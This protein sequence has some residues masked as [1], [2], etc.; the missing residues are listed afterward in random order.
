ML[1]ITLAIVLSS[2]ALAQ[3]PFGVGTPEPA[4]MPGTGGGLFGP[5]FAQIAAWQSEFYRT[6]T[7]ALAA[8]REDGAAFWLLG[9]VSF[10][11]GIF[12]AAGPGH[13]KAVISAYILA[14]G[15]TLRRGVLIAFIASFVQ[16]L[17]AVVLVS[18]AAGV[19]RVTAV[20]MT[21]ATDILEIGSYAL[22]IFIGVWMI[23]SKIFR[24]GHHHSPQTDHGR[25]RWRAELVPANATGPSL[26]F[27]AHDHA[28]HQFLPGSQH[29][30]THTVD[31][32]LLRRPLT[33]ASAWTAIAAVGIRPCTGAVIVL[34]FALSQGLFA[35]GIVST[36]LM[37]LGTAIT[38]AALA[39]LAV[40]ARDTA[41]RL[42][43]KGS[44][45]IPR[46]IRG[47]EIL[48]AAVLVLLGALLL[49]G[50]L[51]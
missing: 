29:G 31:P 2:A 46:V 30:H 8:L 44:T 19:L 37:A 16:A 28:D 34:V 26:A 51:S 1:G 11:Y 47:M 15:E 39:S 23:Y 14:S 38:V 36:L 10:L 40:L 43:G 3:G 17:V 22:I 13:G 49:G 50:A 5:L 21:A 45:L 27:A 6:L 12:H 4:I 25:S 48:A 18:V 20:S 42:S 33:L 24:T 32:S 9:G 35:A 7:G 41:V